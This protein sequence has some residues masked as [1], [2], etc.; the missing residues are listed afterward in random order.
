[1]LD[2]QAYFTG[3]SVSWSVPLFEAEA[4]CTFRGTWGDER[5]ANFAALSSKPASGFT[6]F[7]D[8]KYGFQKRY[9]LADVKTRQAYQDHR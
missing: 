6:V 9:G 1:M 7:G 2:A 8:M 4:W 5:A 3:T